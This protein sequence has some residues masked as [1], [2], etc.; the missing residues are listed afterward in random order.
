MKPEF[1]KAEYLPDVVLDLD[2]F[3]QNPG[4]NCIN[5][6]MDQKLKMQLL[7]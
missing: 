6:L 2:D 7:S 3:A 5:Y 1:T 4:N